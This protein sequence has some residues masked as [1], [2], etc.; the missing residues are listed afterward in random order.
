MGK[1]LAFLGEVRVE[2]EKV[3]WPTP[4]QTINLTLVVII[5]STLVGIYVGGIDLLMAKLTESI[6]K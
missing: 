5:V 3:S 2:L 1:L 4:R 6:L